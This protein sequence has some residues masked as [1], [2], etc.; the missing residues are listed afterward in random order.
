MMSALT[1]EINAER[2]IPISHIKM[3]R[4]LEYI[5]VVAEI[6]NCAEM[7]LSTIFSLF[8]CYR[9]FSSLFMDQ[10]NIQSFSQVES[11]LFHDVRFDL[12][13]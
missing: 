9:I 4:K 5:R 7:A 10:I 12:R 6:Q 2:N 13:N 1:S 8:K 3:R 11:E